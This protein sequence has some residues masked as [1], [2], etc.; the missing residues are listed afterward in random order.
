MKFQEQ[1]TSSQVVHFDDGNPSLPSQFDAV[2]S[3]V[4]LGPGP[5]SHPR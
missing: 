3:T 1:L 5:G 2:A 4:E